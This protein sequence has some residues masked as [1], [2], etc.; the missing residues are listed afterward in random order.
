M[1]MMNI[2]LSFFILAIFSNVRAATFQDAN[3]S[4]SQSIGYISLAGPFVTL[5]KF[6][7]SFIQFLDEINKFIPEQPEDIKYAYEGGKYHWVITDFDIYIDNSSPYLSRSISKNRIEVLRIGTI[8]FIN[9]IKA[10]IKHLFSRNMHKYDFENNYDDNLNILSNDLKNFIYDKFDTK[11]EQDLIKYENEPE[12]KRL[13]DSAKQIFYTLVHNSE[14]KIQGYFIKISEDGN[15]AHLSQN[16]S[17]YFRIIINE[18]NVSVTHDLKIPIPNFVKL[19][20][21]ISG[22]P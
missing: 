1:K 18:K 12:K 15:Y 14:I 21:N 20:A 3:N 4:R 7:E 10:N 8:Y 5:S 6:D 19:V 16:K 13:R 22:K 17:L 2:I 11:F 9:Y